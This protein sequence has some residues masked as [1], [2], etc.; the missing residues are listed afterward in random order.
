VSL[1]IKALEAA[2][3]SQALALK[4]VFC[5]S[6][7]QTAPEQG[8]QKFAGFTQYATPAQWRPS[9]ASHTHNADALRGVTHTQRR[10][11]GATATAPTHTQAASHTHKH[12]VLPLLL[13]LLSVPT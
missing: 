9:R 12:T 6:G 1:Q 13:L 2:S 5:R 4:P 11:A 8:S 3:F 10:R 7:S